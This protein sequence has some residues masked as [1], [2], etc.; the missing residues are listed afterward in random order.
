MPMTDVGI[1][2]ECLD[3]SDQKTA[4]IGAGTV[5][6]LLPHTDANVVSNPVRLRSFSQSRRRWQHG[7]SNPTTSG[8]PSIGKRCGIS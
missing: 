3:S 7:L 2:Q 4:V 5:I 1:G 6:F 8:V